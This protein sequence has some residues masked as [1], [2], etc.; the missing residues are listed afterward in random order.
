MLPLTFAMSTAT[1]KYAQ[2]FS[3]FI[4]E[5]T[6]L[7]TFMPSPTATR[8]THLW[9]TTSLLP[10]NSKHTFATSTVKRTTLR[11]PTTSILLIY[12]G[13]LYSSLQNLQDYQL[14]TTHRMPAQLIPVFLLTTTT[15]TKT[16]SQLK[17][18]LNF[19]NWKPYGIFV[20]LL[21]FFLLI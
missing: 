14:L 11:Q 2:T 15:S 12:F 21:Y 10:L 3:Y 16:N 6:F 13:D 18:L 4:P 19:Q 7:K 5:Q 8:N 20:L 1:R 9:V 17:P